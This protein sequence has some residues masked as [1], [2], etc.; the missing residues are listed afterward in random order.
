MILSTTCP[1]ILN[2]CADAPKAIATIAAHI[3]NI[4]FIVCICLLSLYNSLFHLCNFTAHICGVHF[5][6]EK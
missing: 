1:L 3:I 2:V 4:F 6:A 5:R